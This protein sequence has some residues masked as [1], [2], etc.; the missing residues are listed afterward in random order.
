MTALP[1]PAARPVKAPTGTQLSCKSWLT[2]AA[3][4]MLQNNLD[5]AVAE[6]PDAL[7]VYGGIGKAARNW[8]AF[9]AI[10]ESLRELNDDE[11]L[12]IQSGKP[13]GVFKTHADAPRVLLANSNLVPA[14]ATWEHFHELDRKGLMMY[15]QMTAGSWIY[16]GSQGIVQGTYETFAEAA[17]QH[18]GGVAKGRW[19]LTAGLG[20]MGGAQ[21]LAATFAGFCSLNIECQQSRIDFRL[22]TRYVDEQAFDLDDALD[23]IAK[24]TAAGEARS[25]ALL[26]NAARLI[27]ALAD[28]CKQGTAIKPDLVT[29]QTSAHD[30]IHGYLPAGWTVEQ[31]K[32]AAADPAQHAELK[33]AAARS[34][35]DHV[36]GM[37]AFKQMGIPTVDYGNNIRQVALD[38]GVTNA[39]DFPGF[40]PAYVRPLFCEGKG[41][42]RWVALSGDPEDIRKT[43]A[44]LKELFPKHEA[45]HRWLDMAAERI[46]FQGLPARICWL[47]LGERHIAGLAFNEMVRS[48]ELKAPIVIGRDHLDSGS[49]ASPNRETEGMKDGSDAVSD[50]P[51]LNALLNTAGGATWVSLHHGGGVG[52]GYSQHSGVV[53]VCDGTDAAAK[54]ISRVLWND[55]ATGVMRHADAGYESAAACARQNELNLP[56][57]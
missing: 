47:G 7:V 9:D 53:I 41:P 20:G 6:N 23:R 33:A 49:V 13:V 38:E 36:R 29:D 5:P 3:Y 54:R 25:I 39:F 43:D 31:W 50:W 34:C 56:S 27:P 57:L 10:C 26:G 14:W 37:L 12:L 2:E 17:R 8:A 40:V 18:Y 44:K 45:L 1:H 15:G 46:A 22:K 4:R 16:I 21:P 28:R 30:L 55:P 42:F 48:G 51:L 52:M 19:V 11:T 32:A 35:A 24:Y